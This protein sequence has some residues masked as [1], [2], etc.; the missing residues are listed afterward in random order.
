MTLVVIGPGRWPLETS[1]PFGDTGFCPDQIVHRLLVPQ[2]EQHEEA[3]VAATIFQSRRFPAYLSA[4][5]D[6][7]LQA[8]A[9]L[10]ITTGSD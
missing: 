8:E 4:G 10:L 2:V 1:V 9:Q 6:S 7:A 3:S 5:R